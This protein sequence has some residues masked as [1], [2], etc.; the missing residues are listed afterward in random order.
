MA[1]S[2]T[3]EHGERMH[4]LFVYEGVTTSVY[5]RAKGIVRPSTDEAAAR[6][7]RGGN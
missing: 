4:G 3:G 5:L 1:S 2:V 6:R 7:G